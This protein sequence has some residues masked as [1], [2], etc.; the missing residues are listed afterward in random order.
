MASKSRGHSSLGTS[1]QLIA[2]KPSVVYSKPDTIIVTSP[3]VDKF[4]LSVMAV[5]VKYG[6]MITNTYILLHTKI[7]KCDI[8]Q[9]IFKM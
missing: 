2:L 3:I 1:F 8:L 7:F 4:S 6:L 5:L 9:L